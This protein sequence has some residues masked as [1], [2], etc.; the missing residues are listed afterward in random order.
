VLTVISTITV[1]HRIV[2]T[3]QQTRHL[4]PVREAQ[5]LPIVLRDKEPAP[6]PDL[7]APET[8]RA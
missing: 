7:P 8:P 4:A 3:Y 5:V 1:V 2:Y 6:R